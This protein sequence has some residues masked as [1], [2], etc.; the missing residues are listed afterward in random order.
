M[1]NTLH[2]LTAQLGIPRHTGHLEQELH[3][4]WLIR[5]PVHCPS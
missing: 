2:N 5:Q 4:V 1:T 3:V